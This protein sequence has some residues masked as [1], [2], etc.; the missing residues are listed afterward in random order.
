[1]GGV[2]GSRTYKIAKLIKLI[3]TIVEN[4]IRLISDC[5]KEISKAVLESLIGW[6]NNVSNIENHKKQTSWKTI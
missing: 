1:M 5:G 6:T 3:Q 2:H 4:K